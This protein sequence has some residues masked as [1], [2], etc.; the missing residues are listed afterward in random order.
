MTQT[1]LSEHSG[2]SLASICNY[3]KNKFEPSLNNA[4]LLARCFG[5]SLD[6]LVGLEPTGA[7]NILQ[8]QLLET[9]A[10]L[11]DVEVFLREAVMGGKRHEK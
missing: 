4:I 9:M 8:K 5:M 3:E 10:R 1:E 11:E 6:E 7:E 2:V